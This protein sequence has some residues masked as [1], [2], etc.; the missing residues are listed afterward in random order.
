M[1]N[2]GWTVNEQK[3]CLKLV[4]FRPVE[5]HSGAHGNILAGPPNIL[6]GPSREKFFYKSLYLS[7]GAKYGLG[8][9]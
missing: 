5:S 3:V 8:Y 9:C 4:D 2:V 6:R 7:N 1:V